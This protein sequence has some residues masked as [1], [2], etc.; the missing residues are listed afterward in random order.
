MNYQT[1]EPQGMIGIAIHHDYN[2]NMVD[3]LLDYYDPAEYSNEAIIIS[4]VK[5]KPKIFKL[6]Y[7]DPRVD[8]K[9]T[10][11]YFNDSDKN[12]LEDLFTFA[13]KLNRFEIIEHFIKNKDDFIRALN[14]AL[15][16]NQSYPIISTLLGNF[17]Y[18]ID[19]QLLD[20]LIKCYI[21]NKHVY[22]S[23]GNKT[24]NVDPTF[25]K[26]IQLKKN[27]QTKK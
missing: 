2:I 22:V 4:V 23:Q 14:I 1:K 3:L 16:F 26:L 9:A 20:S 12:I 27:N 7:D 21:V 13:I 8:I 19:S 24:L 15:K 17:D 5:N 25:T 18:D 6:L 10:V 11:E